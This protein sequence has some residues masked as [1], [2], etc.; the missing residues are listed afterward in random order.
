MR[1]IGNH[2]FWRRPTHAASLLVA[3]VVVLGAAQPMTVFRAVTTAMEP[4][5]IKGEAVLIDTNF[6]AAAT[7]SRGDVVMLTGPRDKLVH[8]ERVIGLPGERVQLKGGLLF[9]DGREAPR[10]KIEDYVYQ[11]EV[12]LPTQILAQYVEALPLGSDGA[13]REHRIVKSDDD[14]M[15]NNT[16]VFQVPPDQY[17]VL[18]DNRDNSA[19]SRTSLGFIPLKAIIGKAISHAG[20]DIE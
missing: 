16:Q 13:V 2:A 12:G 11:F 18:G 14:G 10:R 19:D 8:L 7:P 20:S 6:Y 5:V 3:A 4:S 1:R 17:F 15:L 9:I